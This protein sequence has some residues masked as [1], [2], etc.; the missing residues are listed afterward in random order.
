M[1]KEAC[2]C[3]SNL[4][5]KNCCQTYH[6]GINCKTT[7]ELLKARF[8]AFK[9]QNT[10]FL[11][12]THHPYYITPQLITDLEDSSFDPSNLEIHAVENGQANDNHGSISYSFQ[13]PSA[14][15]METFTTTSLYSRLGDQW[16]YEKDT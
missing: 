14:K 16:F 3:G 8:S 12:E 4:K 1:P 13:Y 9:K 5:Y 15:G 2:P 7:V 11:I 6:S 10:N